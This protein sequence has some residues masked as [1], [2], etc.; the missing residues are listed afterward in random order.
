MREACYIL[1]S[2]HRMAPLTMKTPPLSLTITPEDSNAQTHTQ[3]QWLTHRHAHTH[4]HINRHRWMHAHAHTHTHTCMH[5]NT[6]T[7]STH[8][9][10]ERTQEATAVPDSSQIMH[11]LS[12]QWS[13]GLW[14]KPTRVSQ[15]GEQEIISTHCSPLHTTVP[16]S[17]RSAG[18]R[19]YLLLP[20]RYK[21][22]TQLG[23]VH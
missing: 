14:T 12:H 18:C 3:T 15:Q 5:T 20:A 4:V 7:H 2:G 8:T 19:C 22:R 17:N 13:E 6:Q 16:I 11:S 10:T 1:Q 21:A 23:D 9:T